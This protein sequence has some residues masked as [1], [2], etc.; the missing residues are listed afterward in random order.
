MYEFITQNV[1]MQDKTVGPDGTVIKRGHK[2]VQIDS[3][4]TKEAV[5]E[6]FFQILSLMI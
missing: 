4:Q 5:S 2:E 6:T 3:T 1:Q